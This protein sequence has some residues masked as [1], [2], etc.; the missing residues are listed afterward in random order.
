MPPI[1]SATLPIPTRPTM[2][3][4]IIRL[5]TTAAAC[6]GTPLSVASATMCTMGTDMQMQHSTMAQHSTATSRF[7]SIR[8]TGP[9]GRPAARR[10]SALA[11]AMPGG[12]R[13][14]SASGTSSTQAVTPRVM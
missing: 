1:R 3:T 14:S 11:S 2:L 7:G 12:S 13:I 10:E 6:G 8:G 9:P 5:S 4:S